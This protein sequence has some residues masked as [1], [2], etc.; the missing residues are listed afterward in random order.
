MGWW[1]RRFFKLTD[2]FISILTLN[3]SRY[4][5]D[6]KCPCGG[7]KET[8]L[9]RP[10]GSDTIRRYGFVGRSVSLEDGL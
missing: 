10:R 4:A 7:L 6:L 9:Y 1:L 3:L 8:V 2:T 5:M